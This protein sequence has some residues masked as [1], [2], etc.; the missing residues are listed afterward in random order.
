MKI[1]STSF[2]R[3]HGCTATLSAPDPET[4]HCWPMPPPE[5]PGHPCTSLGQSLVG[6]LLLSPGFWCVQ[7]SFCALQESVL[8]VLCKFWQLYGG[9]NGDLPQKDLCHTQVCCIQNPCPCSRPLLACTFTGDTQ[10]QFWLSLC[11]VSGSSCA[12]GLFE[13][14]EHLWW[15]TSLILNAILLLLP[16]CWGF[17]FSLGCEVSLCGWIQH[18]PVDSCSA[19]SC[20][21]GI[22][23]GKNER[24]HILL[25]LHLMP[26]MHLVE[27]SRCILTHLSLTVI[28]SGDGG[29]TA[30]RGAAAAF[31][32]RRQWCPGR[33]AGVAAKGPHHSGYLTWDGVPPKTGTLA[34]PVWLSDI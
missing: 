11:G 24:V 26:Q 34:T 3:S 10:R 19:V 13:P 31:R 2:K 27:R 23:I 29:A 1:T 33:D 17:S 5:T 25:L 20:S 28:W 7:G 8:P 21:F 6:S 12:Q 16:S 9:V 30:G 18:S 22:L 4:G 15:A 32:G 14:S